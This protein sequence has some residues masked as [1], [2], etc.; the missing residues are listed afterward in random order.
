MLNM[1]LTCPNSRRSSVH[2]PK[3]HQTREQALQEFGDTTGLPSHQAT[4][5]S[6]FVSTLDTLINEL[7][8]TGAAR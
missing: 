6:E 4:A 1:C 7:A 8:E 2:L 3:L 5:I